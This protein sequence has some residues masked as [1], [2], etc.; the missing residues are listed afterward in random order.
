MKDP[1]TKP[2]FGLELFSLTQTMASGCTSNVP[3]T[4]LTLND[5]ASCA[6]DMG[7]GVTMYITEGICMIYNPNTEVEC[8]NNTLDSGTIFRS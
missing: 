8:Y 5:I 6:W 3:K 2:L 1:Y 7:G 4:D